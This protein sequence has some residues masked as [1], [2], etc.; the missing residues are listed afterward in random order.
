M[1]QLR[2]LQTQL[3]AIQGGQVQV[4]PSTYSDTEYDLDSLSKKVQEAINEEREK[5]GVPKV[6]WHDNL[7]YVARLHSEDQAE[8]NIRITDADKP[9][10]YPMIRHEG[11]DRGLTVLERT[12]KSIS[13]F[14]SV[15]ENI[16]TFPLAYNGSYSYSR[17]VGPVECPD[18][19][20]FD[21]EKYDSP[22]ERLE[23]YEE[24]LEEREEAIEDVREVTWLD[25][26][27]R[28]DDE[29]VERAILLWVNSKG[30]RVNLLNPRYTH[31]GVGVARVNNYIIITQVFIQ[32]R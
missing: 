30:H 4:Q 25:R 28:T 18:I 2:V 21:P 7:A 14:R 24:A 31:A 10:A 8:D 5:N 16:V 9:C 13:N 3:A 15:G 1:E 6:I 11:D 26:K 20:E 29:A 23:E 12:R 22:E 17:S 27:W 19:D 32:Q